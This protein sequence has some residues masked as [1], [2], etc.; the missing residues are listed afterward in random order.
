M[1]QHIVMWKLKDYAAGAD[2][3]ENTERLIA[4][5]RKLK[6]KIECICEL[7]VGEN[8]VGEGEARSDVCLVTTFKTLDDLE[9]YQKHP[10]HQKVVAF[11]GEIVSERRVVD[12]NDD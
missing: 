7:Q 9:A 4:E 5:L 8:C 6:E 3:K 1:I 12:F 11:V 10:E 2:K